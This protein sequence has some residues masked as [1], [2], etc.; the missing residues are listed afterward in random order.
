MEKRYDEITAEGSSVRLENT[1][2][3]DGGDENRFGQVARFSLGAFR[4]GQF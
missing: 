2:D 3:N 1:T 4:G